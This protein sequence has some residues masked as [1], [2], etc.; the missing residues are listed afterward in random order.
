MIPLTVNPKLI[1]HI[2]IY[3]EVVGTATNVAPDLEVIIVRN[4]AD[5]TEKS[6]GQPFIQSVK[7]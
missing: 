7:Q 2:N 4:T 1:V 6:L 3:G 5:F